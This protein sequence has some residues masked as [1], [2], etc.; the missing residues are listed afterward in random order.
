[1]DPVSLSCVDFFVDNK[2]RITM[3]VKFN[4]AKGD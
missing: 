1:M 2:L 3:F 4:P